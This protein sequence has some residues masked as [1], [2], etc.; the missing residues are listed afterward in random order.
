MKKALIILVIY[1]LA[2]A[3]L[4]AKDLPLNEAITQSARDVEG[5]LPEGSNVAVVNF[6]SPSEVFSDY[7]IEEL[8]GAL[9][10]GK[11]VVIVDRRNLE[12]IREEMN[13]QLSGDVS[14]E[15]MLS[16]GRQLGAHY[17]VSG[18][19]TNMGRYYRF[20]IIVISVETA[21]IKTQISLNMKNDAQVTALIADDNQSFSPTAYFGKQ[22]FALGTGMEINMNST[23]E[24]AAAFGMNFGFDYTI[25]SLF[26]IGLNLGFSFSDIFTLETAAFFRWY[27]I[28]AF[29]AQADAGL[30]V[31]SDVG[32]KFLIG[33]SGGARL[34]V[35]RNL[36]IE[37]HVRIGY[38]FMLGVG[39]MAGI[40]M[41]F[42]GA[43]DPIGGMTPRP[44]PARKT[45]QK[46]SETEAEPEKEPEKEPVKEPTFEEEVKAIVSEFQSDNIWLEFDSEGRARLM[47]SVV[48]PANSTEFEGLSPEIMASNERTLRYVSDILKRARYSTIIIEG[49][50]NPTSP[51]G[52]AR[53]RE[54]NELKLLSRLRALTVVDELRQYGV[55]LD[56]RNVQGAGSDRLV[57]PY[58]DPQNNWKN[59]RVEFILVQ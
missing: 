57:A 37:P 2:A 23:E 5:A 17:L 33:V 19:L 26:A 59:R 6:T 53:N 55:N 36:Y 8:T 11:K 1:L 13:L 32:P 30:W 38:P 27:F 52:A 21:V 4:Y 44:A 20:R 29:F 14:D 12:L 7:V 51:P 15:S 41:P 48:F 46:E 45:E 58:N 50:S 56:R 16:I 54:E 40:R 43:S 28:D 35:A 31:G 18:S 22:K 42:I 47:V 24:V 39:V 25:N 3:G 10:N 34:P 49:Y 9:V